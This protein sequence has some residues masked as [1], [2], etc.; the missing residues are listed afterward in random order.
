MIYLIDFDKTISTSC[1]CNGMV[2]RFATIDT[3][4]ID[5]QWEQG[6]LSTPQ[7]MEMIF[8]S[9]Q[10]DDKQLLEY[11]SMMTIDPFFL[12]FLALCRRNSHPYAIV[13]DGFDLLISETLRQYTEEPI[14]IYA[15]QMVYRDDQWN[16]SFPYFSEET[17]MQGVSKPSIIKKYQQLDTVTFIGDGYSDFAAVHVADFVFAKDI[18]ATYCTEQGIPYIAY[19][20]F[21]DIITYTE[22]MGNQ[23]IK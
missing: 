22:A 11:I 5:A 20:N 1:S 7:A 15:N 6:L 2:T 10:M 14:T 9:L 17:P 23:L 8:R 19:E 3:T 13:S 18:L 21:Q 12:E 4:E 16:L